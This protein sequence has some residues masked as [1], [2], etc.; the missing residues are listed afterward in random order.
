MRIAQVGILAVASLS[1]P[2]LSACGDADTDADSPAP[3]AMCDNGQVPQ[4]AAYDLEDGSFRWASCT[5]G[6]AYRSVRAVTDDAVY[7]DVSDGTS[8]GQTIA[9]DPADGS[10]LADAPTL[11]PSTPT[12]PGAIEVDGLTVT[13][14]Q[15]DPV[16]V[17][18]ANGNQLWTQPGIWA[19][20]DVYAIDDG[21]VFAVERGPELAVPRLVAYELATGEIR[22]EYS[23]DPYREGLWPWHAEDGRLFTVWENL[24]VRDTGTGD[25]VWNTSY[26][27]SQNPALRLAGVDADDDAVYVGFGTESSGGD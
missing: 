6:N 3:D 1:I 5:D 20:D 11:P 27:P 10:V 19:Y 22:W 24:Q 26:P 25:L 14:G 2:F 7:V 9:L 18:D 16:T 4:A 15:D 23:G 17:S 8:G 21:A 13:G 12:P